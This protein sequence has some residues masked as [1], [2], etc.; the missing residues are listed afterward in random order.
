MFRNR[1][2]AHRRYHPLPVTRDPQTPSTTYG[3]DD[4]GNWLRGV[5]QA[6]TTTLTTSAKC[7]LDAP[8]T[9]TVLRIRLLIDAC[10]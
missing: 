9:A 6:G 4:K 7:Q 10:I 2:E 5:P 3:F 1:R 8:R